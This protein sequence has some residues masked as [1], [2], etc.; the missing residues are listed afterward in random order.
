MLP[1]VI[2]QIIFDLPNTVVTCR[3]EEEEEREKERAMKYVL[4]SNMHVIV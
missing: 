1:H 3:Q 4:M 2:P